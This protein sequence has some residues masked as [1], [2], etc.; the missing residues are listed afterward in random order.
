MINMKKRKSRGDLFE[1]GKDHPDYDPQ[2]EYGKRRIGSAVTKF[3][4]ITGRKHPIVARNNKGNA[5]PC[6]FINIK[7]CRGQYQFLLQQ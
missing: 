3:E 6:K 5:A 7:I 1:P 2:F 4:T